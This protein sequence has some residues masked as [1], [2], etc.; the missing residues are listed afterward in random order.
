VPDVEVTL[1]GDKRHRTSGSDRENMPDE[2]EPGVTYRDVTVRWRAA[3]GVSVDRPRA[4][5]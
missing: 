2:V 4:R 3:S 1:H 5:G